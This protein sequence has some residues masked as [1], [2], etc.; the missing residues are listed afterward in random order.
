MWKRIGGTVQSG[1]IA[2]E[3]HFATGLDALL[4]KNAPVALGAFGF[5]LA[6]VA[7]TFRSACLVWFCVAVR[8][9]KTRPPKG[10]RYEGY[11]LAR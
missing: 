1:T 2:R 10:G 8:D 7:A 3:W 11:G 9:V 6:F 4:R 5:V